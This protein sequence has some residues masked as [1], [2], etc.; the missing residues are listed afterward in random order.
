MRLRNILYWKCYSKLSGD[1]IF[2]F[3]LL[4]LIFL[5]IKLMLGISLRVSCV[6][7]CVSLFSVFILFR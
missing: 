3:N 5:V 1:N 4:V 2:L 7:G 6:V